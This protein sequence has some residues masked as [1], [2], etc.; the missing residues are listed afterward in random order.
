MVGK[1]SRV[2]A[3][4]VIQ[5][6]Y[7]VG[8]VL[9]AGLAFLF[10]HDWRWFQIAISIPGMFLLVFW[11]IIPESPRWMLGHGQK[12]KA[13]ELIKKV[14]KTNDMIVPDDVFEKLEAE[15]SEKDAKNPSL[16]DLFKTSNLRIK[17]ILILFIWFVISATY[18][19]LSWSTN[20]LG[21][22]E[23]LNFFLSGIVEFPSIYFVILT[24]NRWGRKKILVGSMIASGA[25]LLLALI[26]PVNQHWLKITLAM[27][28]KG[29]ITVAYS[30]IFIFSAEQFPTIIRNVAIGACTAAAT[31][32][33]ILVPYLIF[34]GQF[35]KPALFLIIGVSAFLASICS[36]F[37]PET[38][39]R[40]LPE[41]IE[42]GENL[43][44]STR[45][46]KVAFGEVQIM[47]TPK[48]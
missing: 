26:V 14:A 46:K 27:A 24:L 20:D 7:S 4:V 11:W 39:N 48:T 21:G 2:H 35:W 30:V 18:F 28:G 29:S 32:G 47:L 36:A 8:F 42:D 40:E 15:T 12:D 10:R 41:T 22:N 17:S 19:G 37:L 34:L 3:G 44:K 38:H 45:I 16:V 33:A 31:I 9:S 6:F 23:L 1:E 25:T 13:I 43:G 5:L